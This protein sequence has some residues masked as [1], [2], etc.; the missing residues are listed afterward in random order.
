LF[1]I[2]IITPVNQKFLLDYYYYLIL[3]INIVA[4]TKTGRVSQAAGRSIS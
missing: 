3:F 1:I 4:E 2:I